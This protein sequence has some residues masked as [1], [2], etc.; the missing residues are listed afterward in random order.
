MLTFE[1][2]TAVKYVDEDDKS[3]GVYFRDTIFLTVSL[4]P[5]RDKNGEP[6]FH[7]YAQKLD[8]G[9]EARLVSGDVDARVLF[10]AHGP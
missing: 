9:Q 8:D 7:I 5:E 4:T 2:L 10:M 6:I 1:E 3:G